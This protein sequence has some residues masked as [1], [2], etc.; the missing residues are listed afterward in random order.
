[1]VAITASVLDILI[2]EVVSLG[3][4]F[5][6]TLHS[7]H[8]RQDLFSSAHAKHPIVPPSAPWIALQIIAE[9]IITQFC[10]SLSNRMSGLSNRGLCKAWLRSPSRRQGI[11]DCCTIV[12]HSGAGFMLGVVR[13]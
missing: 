7:E 11:E 1:M 3:C 6:E 13:D 12:V 5:A 4:C 10:F 2:I 8:L 9:Q